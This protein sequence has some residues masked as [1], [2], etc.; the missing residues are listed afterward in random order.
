MRYTGLFVSVGK[1]SDV[2]L[3]AA[4]VLT[5]M[6]TSKCVYISPEF[7]ELLK[8]ERR[9]LYQFVLRVHVLLLYVVFI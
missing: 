5:H 3:H 7:I 2:T 9:Q 4:V 8:H 6:H 1:K